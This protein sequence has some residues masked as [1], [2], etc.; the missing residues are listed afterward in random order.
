MP[1]GQDRDDL[2]A[3]AAL[4]PLD[5][6]YAGKT[7]PLHP[8]FSEYGL[9]RNRVR[10]ECEWLLA[11]CAEPALPE[12]RTLTDAE[13][14]QLESLAASF[15]PADAAAVKT[16]ERTTNHDVKAVEYFLKTKL[17]GTSLADIREFVH[18]ACTS[19]D[20]NNLA[21]A[22]QVQEGRRLLRAAQAELLRTL[23]GLALETADTAMLARTHGQSASPTTMGKELAIFVH[24]LHEAGRAIDAITILGK[25]NGAVG[26]YNAHLA[27]CPDVDWEALARHVIETRLQLKQNRFTTQI[28]PHDY[29]AALFDALARWNTILLDLDRDLWTYIS[30]GYFGQRVVAGEVGSSTMPH[31][32]NPI[33][34]ENSEGNIGLANALLHHLAGKLPVSRL[35]RDLSDSTVLRAMGTA[36][37]HSL[38]AVASTRK[39]L[40][41]LT[42]NPVRIAGDLEEAWEVLA[43]PVQTV[44]RR[45]GIPNPY[46]QLKALT[47]GQRVTR[48]TLHA[49]IDALALPAA[50]KTRLKA[51]TPSGYTGLAAR[52]ARDA[53]AQCGA[54]SDLT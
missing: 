23:G 54:I 4:G 47:R 25:L 30:M 3:L 2:Q 44:M 40:G 34:F 49:F 9:I 27:A 12:C 43:E 31:K 38:L 20:I 8:V 5:G 53:V 18:F 19:E 16:I 41:R 35:Q 29:L 26:H 10:V 21:H 24:R 6:R 51:L 50:D 36:F 7:A 48:E 14:G 32:V 37:G 22:L 52:L 11:L 42:L 17:E 15:S 33:D 1:E 45:A 28:E 13:R 39:G 46:E